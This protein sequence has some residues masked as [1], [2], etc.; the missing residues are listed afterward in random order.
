MRLLIFQH[1]SNGVPTGCSNTPPYPLDRWN[2]V[3][4]L[5]AP[6]SFPRPESLSRRV[7]TLRTH[8]RAAVSLLSRGRT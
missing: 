7:E 8:R 2:A 1:P 4:A 3:V 6:P 5:E